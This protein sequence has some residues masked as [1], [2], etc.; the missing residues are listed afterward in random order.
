VK[1]EQS[2]WW[3]LCDRLSKYLEG[4]AEWFGKIVQHYA[5]SHRRYHNQEHI[6][7]CLAEYRA[8]PRL[9]ENSAEVELALWLHDV[10]YDPRRGDNEEQSAEFARQLCR[11]VRA[12]DLVERRVVDLILVTKHSAT[13]VNAGA[14]LVVDID[15]AILGQDEERFWR[16]EREVREEYGFVPAEV[17]RVKRA[18]ILE[19]FLE[20]E[21]IYTTEFFIG[22]YEERARE[23]LRKSI[24]A[25]RN[26]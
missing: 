26:G 12:C 24:A 13:P 10:I 11:D 8:A 23:N 7:H 19:K 22:K 25:L 18:E 2:E 3:D 20:R 5:E 14:R 16:Y 1:L 9:T 17:F 6:V 15:L 4:D 21:R